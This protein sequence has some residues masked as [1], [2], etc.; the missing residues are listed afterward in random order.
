LK[1]GCFEETGAA[2]HEQR[3][4]IEERVDQRRCRREQKNTPSPKG[5][6]N[7]QTMPDQ[8]PKRPNFSALGK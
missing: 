2:A 5:D 7:Q 6:P 3:L 1:D 8:N 4:A